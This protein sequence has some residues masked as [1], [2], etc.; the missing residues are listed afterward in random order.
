MLPMQPPS[1]SNFMIT[2]RGSLLELGKVILKCVRKNNLAK[3]PLKE[4]K[5]QGVG[6]GKSSAKY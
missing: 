3:M 4:K 1:P 5:Y 2:C 6:S